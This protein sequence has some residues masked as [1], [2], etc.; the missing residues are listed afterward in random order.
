MHASRP[1]GIDR[2]DVLLW[3]GAEREA[4]ALWLVIQGELGC[5]QRSQHLAR[6]ETRSI[7]VFDEDYRNFRPVGPSITQSYATK[8]EKRC[9]LSFT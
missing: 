7:L 9:V 2:S 4:S 1:I 3:K 8:E 5:F 6:L